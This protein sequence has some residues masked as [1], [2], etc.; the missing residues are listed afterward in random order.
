MATPEGSIE[1]W[2]KHDDADWFSNDKGY[3]FPKVVF[4]GVS[5][6]S[7]K[8]PDRTFVVTLSGLPHGTVNFTHPVPASDSRGLFVG[9]TWTP[10]R[11]ILYLN[12]REVDHLD[13]QAH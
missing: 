12:G 1:F 6:E 11:V 10:K 2:A 3:T 13:I 8:N 9:I 4:P 5:V 7:V